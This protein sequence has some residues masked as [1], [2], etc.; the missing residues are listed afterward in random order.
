MKTIWLKA[1]CSAG[2]GITTPTPRGGASRI[3]VSNGRWVVPPQERPAGWQSL[4]ISE[5]PEDALVAASE[6]VTAE[7]AAR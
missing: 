1:T 4:H 7:A 6:A 3:L 2:A 5:T